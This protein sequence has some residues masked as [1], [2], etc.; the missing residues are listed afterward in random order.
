MWGGFNSFYSPFSYYGGFYNPYG[1][2]FRNG[3][4]NNWANRWNRFDDY[5]GNNFNQRNKRDYRSTVARIKSGRGEK[6]YNSPKERNKEKPQNSNSRTRNV[7]NTLNRINLGRG[8]SSPGRNL[9]VGY[10]RNR[11]T[12]NINK[13]NNSR[14]NLRPGESFNSPNKD[15][16]QNQLNTNLTRS[17]Q[18]LSR[19]S[20]SIQNQYRFVERSPE[21]SSLRTRQRTRSEAIVSPRNSRNPRSASRVVQRSTK[22]ETKS[23][24]NNYRSQ[25]NNRYSRSNNSY[26]RY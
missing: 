17:P 9:V 15:L 10:D 16:R 18:G 22:N 20:R 13:I 23:A 5:Y 12:D 11:L 7:Q 3:F 8:V 24:S 19:G 21:R 2:G 26:K 4:R 14:R 25:R 1:F 6:T